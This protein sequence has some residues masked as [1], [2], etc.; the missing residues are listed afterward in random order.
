MSAASPSTDVPEPAFACCIE[1]GRT[2]G[3]LVVG[4]V[5]AANGDLA[6]GHFFEPTIFAGVRPMDRFGQVEIFGPVL[7]VTGAEKRPFFT[8]RCRLGSTE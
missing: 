4:G 8:L 2:E 7:S 6:Q 5:R 3:E 1:V